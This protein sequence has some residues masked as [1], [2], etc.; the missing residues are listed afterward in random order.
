MSEHAGPAAQPPS[1]DPADFTPKPTLAYAS[2][3]G[4]QAAAVGAFVSA[5][6]NA[7]GTHK[8]GASGFLTRTGGTIG[9]FGASACV[10]GRE[11]PGLSYDGGAIL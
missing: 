9:F 2:A 3:I 4:F 6:Q 5:I 10:N 8:A 11:H 1:T 7:L